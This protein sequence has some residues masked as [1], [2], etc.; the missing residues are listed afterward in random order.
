MMQDSYD[1]QFKFVLVGDIGVGKTSLLERY[2]YNTFSYGYHSSGEN[3]EIRTVQ[4]EEQRIKLQL[5]ERKGHPDRDPGTIVNGQHAF[6]VVFDLTDAR[7]FEKAK[8]LISENQSQSIGGPRFVLV[9]NKF[10]LSDKRQVSQEEIQSFLNENAGIGYVEASAESGFNVNKVFEKAIELS[11]ERQ[12]KLNPN[13]NKNTT[14]GANSNSSRTT[15]KTPCCFNFFNNFFHRKTKPAVH[16]E[17]TISL[18]KIS[19]TN[20]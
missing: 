20:Q 15:E 6:I 10:D 16:S 11:L 17:E 8:A 4:Y 9:G 5:L 14:K 12:R 3:F 1:S 18:T 7:S 2:L 13:F 19:K